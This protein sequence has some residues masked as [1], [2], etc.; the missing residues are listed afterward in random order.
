MTL[1]MLG[2]WALV[3]VL[4]VA[5]LRRPRPTPT[6]SPSPTSS[7]GPVPRRSWPSGWPA[8]SST[9][10]STASASGPSRRPPTE[11]DPRYLRR[12]SRMP[13]LGSAA[14]LGHE[15]GPVGQLL[16]DHGAEHRLIDVPVHLVPVDAPKRR[17][18]IVLDR[19]LDPPGGRLVVRRATRAR[20]M[21]MPADTPAEVM[22]LPSST[23][24]CGR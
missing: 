9:P 14:Q 7:H 23:H 18:G 6:S 8:A 20:A 21:S 2:L 1:G 15:L 17:V 22:N 24:R 10:R 12:P 4:A 5:L 13:Q 3:A 19:Q 11:P 16:L